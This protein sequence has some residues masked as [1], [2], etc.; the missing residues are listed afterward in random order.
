ML[1]CT[2]MAIVQRTSFPFCILCFPF[3][4]CVQAAIQIMKTSQS[5]VESLHEVHMLSWHQDLH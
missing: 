1:C 5:K 4:F 3:M 2:G